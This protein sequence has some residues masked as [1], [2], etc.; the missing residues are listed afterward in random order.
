VALV[1]EIR[2]PTVGGRPLVHLTGS[3]VGHGMLAPSVAS[4]H[5]SLAAL[6]FPQ[7]HLALLPLPLRHEAP[8]I[9]LEGWYR[10]LGV[11]FL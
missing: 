4:R 3:K 2:W 5:G 10:T 11:V 7:F 6:S 9:V 8:V 1:S